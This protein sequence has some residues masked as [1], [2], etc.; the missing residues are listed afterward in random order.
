MFQCI[1]NPIQY[2][3]FEVDCYHGIQWLN[4]MLSYM[5][6]WSEARSP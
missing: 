1:N 6:G 4:P 3:L 2:R 5:E